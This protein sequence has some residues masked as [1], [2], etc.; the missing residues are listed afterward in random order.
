MKIEWFFNNSLWDLTEEA[1]TCSKKEKRKKKT[2]TM[3]V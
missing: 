3:D 2:H 1:V